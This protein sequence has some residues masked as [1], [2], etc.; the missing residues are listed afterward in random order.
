[1]MSPEPNEVA[2]MPAELKSFP[3]VAVEAEIP[4]AT[5]RDIEHFIH[6]LSGAV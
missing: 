2:E 1:M 6:R 3:A 5:Q 4:P